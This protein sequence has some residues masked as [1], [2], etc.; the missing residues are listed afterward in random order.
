ML[1]PKLG[2]ERESSTLLLLDA[3]V[4]P[5]ACGRFSSF[6]NIV[7]HIH[8]RTHSAGSR[9]FFV[10]PVLCILVHSPEG[11]PRIEDVLGAFFLWE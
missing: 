4:T 5:V 1:V 6:N 10:R 7:S 8:R 2:H 3:C 9:I 11:R